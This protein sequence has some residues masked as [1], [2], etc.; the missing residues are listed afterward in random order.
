ML[1]VFIKDIMNESGRRV[2]LLEQAL[3]IRPDH[4]SRRVHVDNSYVDYVVF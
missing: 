1:K 2:P 4:L 3:L